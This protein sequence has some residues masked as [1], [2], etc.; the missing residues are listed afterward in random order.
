MSIKKI[1]GAILY[2]MVLSSGMLH[3]Q[4]RNI[5]FNFNQYSNLRYIREDGSGNSVKEK[6]YRKTIRENGDVMFYIKDLMFLHFKKSMK[7][8]TF[9]SSEKKFGCCEYLEVNRLESFIKNIQ[10][11]Y[12][13]GYKH[14]SDKFP[15]ILFFVKN[16][17]ESITMYE[18]KWQYYI[19]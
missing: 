8:R 19:E 13:F 17:D 14:P 10:E 4:E 6:M 12:P 18:V 11:Q 16:E 15:E 5:C 9:Q 1:L 3:G 2:L 7:S